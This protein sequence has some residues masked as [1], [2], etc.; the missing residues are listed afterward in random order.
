MRDIIYS[1]MSILLGVT[2]IASPSNAQD[3]AVNL[4]DIVDAVQEMC[5]HPD[6]RGEYLSITGEVEAGFLVRLVGAEI[7]GTI[8][9]ETWEGFNQQFDQYRTDPRECAVKILPILLNGL[10]VLSH[11]NSDLALCIQ[12]WIAENF[13]RSFSVEGS[14]RCPSRGCFLESGNCNRRDARLRY[15]AISDYYINDYEF[16][17]HTGN[18]ANTGEFR[19]VRD[20]FG[21]IIE[22][23]VGLSCDPPNRIGA[24]GG[25]HSGELRG[26]ILHGDFESLRERVSAECEV[27]GGQ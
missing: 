2:L 10:T 1:G 8:S 22:I 21:K 7:D 13:L 14:V 5:L 16:V 26:T 15:A 23:S 4:S 24:P 12:N 6:R 25:W 9:H 3:E 27:Q 11:A 17:E 18:Y 20:S 19:T